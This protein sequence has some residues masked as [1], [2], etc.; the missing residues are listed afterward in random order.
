MWRGRRRSTPAVSSAPP[1]TARRR[2]GAA[3]HAALSPSCRSAMAADAQAA[4]S[5]TLG[6]ARSA[7]KHV[8]E[9]EAAA[10][11]SQCCAQRCVSLDVHRSTGACLSSCQR[12]SLVAG[13]LTGSTG[14]SLFCG[15]VGGNEGAAQGG[16]AGVPAQGV[17]LGLGGRRAR[18]HQRRQVGAPIPWLEIARCA[19]SPYSAYRV[20]RRMC[21]CLHCC[22]CSASEPEVTAGESL[23]SHPRALLASADY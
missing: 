18:P 6:H 13:S 11:R 8:P 21:F 3:C 12:P 22:S 4:F 16:T 7:L 5:L 10:A 1:P 9:K 19:K 17:H 2:C 15:T 20:R 14:D 23:Q